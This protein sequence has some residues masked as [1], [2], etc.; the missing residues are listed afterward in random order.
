MDS[1]HRF[2]GMKVLVVD[3][4][5]DYVDTLSVLLELMGCKTFVAYDGRTALQLFHHARPDIVFLDL[6]MPGLDGCDAALLVQAEDIA[7]HT[8]LACVTGRSEPAD[9]ERC[10]RAGF[11]FF[12]PKPH[13]EHQLIEALDAALRRRQAPAWPRNPLPPEADTGRWT[14]HS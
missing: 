3:D 1:S 13:E 6:D 7:G 2:D 10:R 4:N 9:E 14:R 8:L 11:D 5:V 12:F